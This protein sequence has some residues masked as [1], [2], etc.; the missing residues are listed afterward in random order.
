MPPLFNMLLYYVYAL[1]VYAHPY[2]CYP[3]NPVCL[4][5]VD[6]HRKRQ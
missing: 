5:A 6:G 4:D 1:Y 2:Y 3:I